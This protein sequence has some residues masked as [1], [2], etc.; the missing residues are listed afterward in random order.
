MSLSISKRTLILI[1]LLI[2]FVKSLFDPQ[3]LICEMKGIYADAQED[4]P[5]NALI[6]R[7]KSVQLNCFVDVDHGGDRITRRSQ[8]RIIL[9]GNLAPLLWYSKR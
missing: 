9:F 1:Y 2:N 4:I 5:T 6:S 8:T 7:G 3:N